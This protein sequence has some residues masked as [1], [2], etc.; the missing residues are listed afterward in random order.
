MNVLDHLQLYLKDMTG[1]NS[2]FAKCLARYVNDSDVV[3]LKRELLLKKTELQ[4]Q[5]HELDLE[6]MKHLQMRKLS[7]DDLSL[8]SKRMIY[9]HFNSKKRFL[10]YSTLDLIVSFD[11]KFSNDFEVLDKV[12]G[13]QNMNYSAL[14]LKYRIDVH[15]EEVVEAFFYVLAN[16]GNEEMIRVRFKDVQAKATK[17]LDQFNQIDDEVL[18]SDIGYYRG[19]IDGFVELDV[20]NCFQWE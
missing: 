16:K 13:V 4:N 9:H 14:T 6:L 15:V 17:M 12:L 18:K 8:C 7:V 2:I 19:F 10:P 5:E 1:L 20:T 11:K 3:E